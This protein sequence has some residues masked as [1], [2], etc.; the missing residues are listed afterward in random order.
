MFLQ[1]NCW[2]QA[3]KEY[4]ESEGASLAI[5]PEFLAYYAMPYVPEISKHPSFKD[6]FSVEWAR[7]LKARL[8]ELLSTTP[9]FAANPR[10]LEM[11]R[12]HAQLS[13]GQAARSSDEVGNPL[14]DAAHDMEALKK[15]L[16]DSELRAVNAKQ[17]SAAREAAIQR[18]ARE[19]VEL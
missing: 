2:M 15:R 18:G 6:L 19:G 8:A 16:V 1:V 10:L 14:T 5:T 17:D 13:G 7:A 3:F 12:T 11:Y 4:L 9:Q